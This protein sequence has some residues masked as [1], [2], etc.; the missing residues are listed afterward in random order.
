MSQARHFETL[1]YHT[2]GEP[3]RILRGGV[4]VIAGDTMLEKRRYMQRHHDD[5]RQLL[6]LEPR[7]HANMYG[8]VLTEP[9]SADSDCGVL[10]L[11][12]EG[13]AT[14]CGH[15][16]IALATAA[17]EHQLFSFDDPSRIRI[18]T[19]AGQVEANASI[20]EGKVESVSF[21]NV[22]SFVQ[23]ELTVPFKGKDLP[24]T[25]VF[26]GVYYAFVD[27]QDAGVELV[28]ENAA[29]LAA[30]SRA[31]KQAVSRAA[32]IRHPLGDE[33]LNFLFG[34]IFVQ[35]G[36]APGQSRQVCL[37]ADGELDRSPCGTGV[38][39]RAAIQFARVGMAAGERLTIESII[40]TSFTV[41]CV[42]ETETGGLAAV[43]TRVTGS[44]YMTGEHKFV[45][46]GE[47]PL[48]QGFFIR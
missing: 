19:P 43:L 35:P 4:P 44:A 5:I 21:L 8:A 42:G 48:K 22:P 15:G 2:A 26:S 24:V 41:E 34:V 18:D 1:D 38:S 28:P 10:F 14:M 32:T 20:K 40:G 46:D 13:Y 9:V 33:D 11:H 12:N 39:G 3:L 23:Q 16:I 6:M 29:E 45:L 17:V 25:I 31:I 7:G 37:F 36:D 30:D 47:D 27:A